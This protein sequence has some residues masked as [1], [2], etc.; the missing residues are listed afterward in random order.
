MARP[1]DAI[2]LT[3]AQTHN[4]P[5]QSMSVSG[6]VDQT[7]NPLVKDASK[8][9][10]YVQHMSTSISDLPYFNILGQIIDSKYPS[11][12]EGQKYFLNRTNMSISINI[13]TIPPALPPVFNYDD[14]TDQL[15]FL[16][17]PQPATPFQPEISENS[18]AT[19]Y[20]QYVSENT[21]GLANAP[22][23]GVGVSSPVSYPL[24]YY[25]VHSIQQFVD[26]IN[27]ALTRMW[28]KIVNI[29]DNV[30]P[31]FTYDPVTQLYTFFKPPNDL[32]MTYD[33]YVNG[34]LERYLDAFRWNYYSDTNIPKAL[35]QTSETGL[36]NLLVY[37]LKSV[38]VPTSADG[39][40]LTCE[41]A[42]IANLVDLVA[43]I[44]IAGGASDFQHVES[45]YI[46]LSTDST[47]PNSLPSTNAILRFPIDPSGFTS[48]TN[49]AT[50]EYNAV[51]LDKKLVI[52]NH[53][54]LRNLGL[55]PYVQNS[56]N[57]LYPIT[58]PCINGRFSITL[59]MFS[60]E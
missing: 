47:I 48:Q 21:Y 40:S 10:L 34:Y 15:T 14:N 23:D 58:L 35:P 45:Q 51:V 46:P 18:C 12:P 39:L 5:F 2:Y 13:T 37:P 9:D 56:K 43:I 41:Y 60:K 27:V 26:M 30:C 33:I 8:L 54:E 31:Y 59:A 36:N 19:A 28:G 38:Y 57:Q 3:L 53:T 6:A 25:D 16:V 4:N 50:I 11:G 52:K 29:A 44:V 32:G 22:D 17:P 55:I 20:L 24:P 42:C 49:N 1:T 7:T